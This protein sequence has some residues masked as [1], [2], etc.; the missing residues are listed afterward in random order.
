MPFTPIVQSRFSQIERWCLIIS[1]ILLAFAGGLIAVMTHYYRE[2]FYPGVVID[3]VIASGKTKAEIKALLLESENSAP[4]FSLTLHVDDVQIAS[5]ATELGGHYDYDKAIDEAYSIGRNDSFWAKAWRAITPW[6]QTKE[7]STNYVIDSQH[8]NE[9]IDALGVVV[10]QPAEEP[11][12]NLKFSQTASS[13]KILPGKS[14]RLVD[15]EQTVQKVLERLQ[16]GELHIP[17]IVAS[18]SAGLAPEQIEPAAERAKKLVGKKITFR[19]DNVFREMNDQLLVNILAFP[20]GISSTHLKPVME[21]LAKEVNRE[22]QD[23]EFLY[24][25]DTLQVEKFSPPRKGL[26]LNEDQFTTELHQLI[27]TLETTDQKELELRLPVKEAEPNKGLGDTNNLGIKEQ[28]GFG[29]SQY[30]HSIPN[31]IHNVALTAQKIN[32]FIIKPGEEFSFNRALGDVSSATGFKSAY[33]IRN[34]RTELGD[35]GGVCQVS[36]TLFRA[37]LNGG[38]PVTKRKAHSYRVSYYEL[39]AK[40]GIDATVYSGEV[41]LRFVNDTGHHILLHTQTDSK[42]LY[43]TVELYG[44]SDGRSAEIVDHKVWDQRGAPAPLYID[45]PSVPKGQIRQVDFATS[46]IKASFKNIVKDKD[47]KVLREDEYYSNYVPWRAVFLRG[48]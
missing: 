2:K 24:N 48:V 39:N 19:A 41:D 5:S 6:P 34:G 36:T 33:V 44:T 20:S 38:L 28:I 25:K 31:R 42:K 10:D 14:G 16:P 26:A 12:A 15:R 30:A 37:V 43:M 7:I 21:E 35:G 3:N 1:I 45:D 8:L 46:G 23:A 32:N 27:N 29:E 40:P 17:A 9:Q 22:P 13:L 18:V 4:T 11:S 47:G